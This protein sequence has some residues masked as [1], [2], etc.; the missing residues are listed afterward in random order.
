MM[1]H[2]RLVFALYIPLYIM[3]PSTGI[4]YSL[5]PAAS[6]CIIE[7]LCILR[8]RVFALVIHNPP[9]IHNGASRKVLILGLLRVFVPSSP[10][11]VSCSPRLRYIVPSLRA[12]RR[13]LRIIRYKL[14]SR[15]FL[16]TMY[17]IV[18]CPYSALRAAAVIARALHLVVR[19][20]SRCC[21]N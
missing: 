15:A 18:L 7:Q 2:A 20:I 4:F 5:P 21:S 16:L 12:I 10:P 1:Y 19:R 3:H 14:R 9:V 8:P 11:D 6:L 13:T 17:I